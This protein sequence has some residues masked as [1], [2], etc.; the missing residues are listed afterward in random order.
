MHL[1][2]DL[3]RALEN[4]LRNTSGTSCFQVSLRAPA[5]HL[6]LDSALADGDRK[7]ARHRSV[8]LWSPTSCQR[9]IVPWVSRVCS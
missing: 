6:P 5:F 3:Y 2:G 1:S 9:E 8:I 4:V 7:I